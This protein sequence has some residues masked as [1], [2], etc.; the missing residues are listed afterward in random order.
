MPADRARRAS[1]LEALLARAAPVEPD[2]RAPVAAAFCLFF[3]V[4]GGYFAVRPVRETVGT[5]LGEE[6]VAEL[7][8]ATWTASLLV[9]PAYGWLVARFRRS[10]LL[11][12]IYGFIASVLAIAGFTLQASDDSIAVGQLFY[13][14]ISVLNLFIVSVFWS[15]LLELFESR[16]TKRLFGVIAAGGTTGALLGPLLTDLTVSRIGNGG[17]LYLGAALFVAAIFFQRVLIAIWRDRSRA[18]APDAAGESASRDRPIGGNPL[19]GITLVLRS[20]YLLAIA[21]F[22]LLLASVTTF[23][24]FEQL[25]LVSEEFPDTEQRTRVFARLDWI[26]QSLTVV[27]QIF[28]TGRIASRLGLTVLLTIVPIVMMLGFAALA[29]SGT[30]AVLAVVFVIR[31]AGEYAFVRPGREMLFS[32]LDTETKYKAKN[33]IDVV[34]YRGADVLTGQVN[35]AL[36]R[37]GFLPVVV[38]LLGIATSALWAVNGWWLGRRHDAAAPEAG[39]I[40]TT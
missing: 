21:L 5:I 17:V 13:V 18:S 31:R 26:V 20:P 10:V 37:A 34:V 25:R 9:I 36:D 3:C 16:Q 8:F 6:R 2:E 28:L 19:A 29:A 30:F 14:F 11:P 27:S 24:Y 39:A 35:T 15:F 23:L 32:R 33:L 4:L 12:S 40:K 1:P 22:V 7:Y 38:A